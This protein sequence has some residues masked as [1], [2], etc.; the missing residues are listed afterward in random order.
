[1]L[2][3]AIDSGEVAA[4]NDLA[5]LLRDEGR[6]SEAVQVLEGAAAAG[7]QQALANIVELHLEAGNLTAA[8]LAAEQYAD[9]GRLDDAEGYYRWAAELGGLRAHSAY[10]QFLLAMRGDLDR[11]EVEFRQAEQHAEPGWAYALG[12]FLLDEGRTDEARYYLQI[13]VDAG[14]ADAAAAI[15]ELDGDDP[16][17][18]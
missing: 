9:E 17:D 16:M 12:R 10:G 18:D 2:R 7:D 5:I 6:L 14:D 4:A 11:A 1:M 3:L 13:A 15:A 8:A